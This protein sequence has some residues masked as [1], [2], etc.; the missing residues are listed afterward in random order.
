MMIPT[1]TQTSQASLC[2]PHFWLIPTADGAVSVG[3]CKYCGKH[4]PFQ[5][6]IP[7]RDSEGRAFLTPVGHKLEREWQEAHEASW[8]LAVRYS[9]GNVPERY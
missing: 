4:K 1:D 9:L 3:V 6:S 5:N 7:E 8:R 2:P